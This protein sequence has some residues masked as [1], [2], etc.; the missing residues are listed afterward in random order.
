MRLRWMLRVVL[1]G[2][3]ATGSA[4]DALTGCDTG[5]FQLRAGFEGAGLARCAVIE[6]DAVQLEVL[7]EDGG[8]INPSPWYGFHV[9]ALTA[10]AG[11][12]QVHLR[13]GEHKHRYHPKVSVDGRAWQRLADADVELRDGGAVLR[14]RPSQ[15]G[16]YVSAQENLNGEYYR[17]WRASIAKRAGAQWREVGRTVGDR[18]IWALHTNAGAANYI[19]LLGRQHPPEVSGAMAFMRFAERLLEIERE[20][21]PREKT[22]LEGAKGRADAARCRFFR[23]HGFV[24][25]PLLNPDGVAAGHWR[26]NL[27]QTDLNRDWGRFEQPETHAVLAVVDDLERQRKRLRVMLDFHSTRRN[28]FYTQDDDSPTRPADFAKRWLDAAKAAGTPLYAFEHAPRPLRDQGT[29][30]NYY[31]RRFGVPSITYEV[32]D[33]ENRKLVAAS[34][35]TFAT[36][37]VDVLAAEDDMPPAVCADLFC[38]L[39]AANQASSVMLAEEQLLS[40]SAAVTIAAATAWVAEEQARPGAARSSNYLDFEARLVELAGTAASNLHIGRSRQDLHGTMRRMLV[41][42]RWLATMHDQLNARRRLLALATREA[43]TPVP[44]YTHGVQAQPT[45]FGHYL[46]AFSAALGRDT[47]R[48]RQGFARL[49]RSPLGAA[50][51]GTSGFALNR[52]RLAA[53]LGFDA[54]VENSLDANLVSSADYKLELASILSQSAVAV[55]RFAQDMHTQYHDPQPWIALHRSSTSGSS[56]MPQK[57]NPRAIDRLRSAASAVVGQAHQVL[58]DAHN[59]NTGMHDYRRLAP[60]LALADQADDLY[61]R[62]ALLLDSLHVDAARALE[63]LRRGYST[64]T[65]VADL[66]VREADVPFRDAHSYASALVDLCRRTNQPADGVSNKALRRVYEQTLGVPLPVSP[67]TIRDALQPAAMI[68]GR[69]GFGGPQPA[70]MQRALA[71]HGQALAADESWL[72]DTEARLRQARQT[73]R[74]AFEELRI[75]A[76]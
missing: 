21:C 6:Q 18:P 56:I 58:L 43:N 51:L 16:I 13:Y 7:P 75:G 60:T 29:A 59:V 28:V 14:L 27:R 10:H 3:A 47:E 33:E 37:L 70:E 19:L 45:T 30:K 40:P 74:E 17:A 12:L 54:P 8:R 23:T 24:M 53:L 57:R 69:R 68:A 61:R 32:A 26:H 67:Q 44:A 63:E 36:A 71:A 22:R 11:N 31:Y 25:V 64:M 48:T 39:I 1:L 20:D 4:N 73:L 72:A 62:Y 2:M 9:R 65:A 5:L 50:A 66:L 34:A 46:L 42:Q 76:G 15:Q 35:A 38:L 52:H 41:R 55:G 49:N